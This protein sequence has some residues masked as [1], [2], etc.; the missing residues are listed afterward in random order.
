MA[1]KMIKLLVAALSRV[2]C[3]NWCLMRLNKRGSSKKGRGVLWDLRRKMIHNLRISRMS[4]FLMR[5][6]LMVKRRL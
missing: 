4:M 2:R 1:R 3:G 5:M 6:W